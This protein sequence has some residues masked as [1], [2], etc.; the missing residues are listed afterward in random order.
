[1]SILKNGDLV[2][3]LDKVQNL[4]KVQINLHVF[5]DKGKMGWESRLCLGV[6]TAKS[7]TLVIVS[8]DF[9]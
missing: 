1:M 3:N 6:K 9:V 7:K 2:Q 5:L 8:L 4:E